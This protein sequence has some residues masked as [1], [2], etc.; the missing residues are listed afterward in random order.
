M[1]FKIGIDVG[2]T[3]T[4]FLLMDNKG[5]S[6]IFKVLSSPEDPSIAVMKG[7]NQMARKKGISLTSFL[8]KIEIIVHGTTVTTNAVLTGNV[9]RTGLMTTKGFRDALQMRR[10]IREEL[11]N[12]KYLPPV[13]IVP[14]H[15]RFPVLERMDY[16]G[17]LVTQIDETDVIKGIDLFKDQDIEA[18]AVCFM[19]SYANSTHEDKAK[20]MIRKHMPDAYLSVSSSVLPQIRFYDRVSTT[21][22]NAAVG[23]IL[24]GYLSRLAARLL[25][26]RFSGIF[27]IMQSNGG[28][29]TPEAVTELAASTLLSGP[30]AAP[31]AGIAYAELHGQKSFITVDMGGTS[32][33]AALIKDAQPIVTMDGKVN[34]MALALPMMEI[35]TIG[36]G[37]GS[38]AWIDEGGLLRM[39]PQSAGAYP[40]PVC[41]GLGGK[42]PSCSDANLILGYLS[43]DFFAGGTMKLDKPAAEAAIQQTVATPM[44]MDLVEAAYGMYHIMNVNMASAIREI[45]VQRGFDPRDFLLVCG[46][47]A[48]PIHAAMIALELEISKILIPK[49]S[50]IFCAA[51]M[52]LSDLKHDFVRSFHTSFSAEHIEKHHWLSLVKNLEAEGKKILSNENIPEKKRRFQFCLDLR[53]I[54]QYHEVSVPIEIEDIKA[55]KFKKMADRFHAEHNRLYGYDLKDEETAVELVNIRMTAIGTTDKPAFRKESFAGRDASPALKG[56]RNVFIPSKMNF[57]SIDIYDG[58]KMGF[59][60]HVSGPVIIE[61]K[62]TTIFVPS[63]FEIE[64]DEYGSFMMTIMHEKTPSPDE[65]RGRN[66]K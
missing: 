49:E 40:G 31:M 65:K 29:T 41:Y 1:I 7:L 34:R 11:Y 62:N 17:N 43:A 47:G 37:G 4:D 60:N 54:G 19:H 32:F 10:G 64:C 56:K 13:P 51:G 25:E 28:V 63:M 48:G 52:L 9:S 15:L 53:Y 3:F 45:S 42:A 8:G 16:A 2:G 22:L 44:K 12:N 33:D 24:K 26:N 55:L 36:A 61:Q 5:N 23:P 57:A 21:V 20:E 14:R 46:G 30:A 18:V 6:D 35:N 38:I 58:N 50:S 39:G 27:L 66:G 59:G